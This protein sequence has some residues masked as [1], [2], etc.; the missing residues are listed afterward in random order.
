MRWGQNNTSRLSG[1]PALSPRS[2]R[3]FVP[4]RAYRTFFGRDSESENVVPHHPLP[5]E[6]A[7]S[8]FVVAGLHVIVTKLQRES[9]FAVQ[10]LFIDK[11]T[12]NVGPNSTLVI[13][14]FVAHTRFSALAACRSRRSAA[15]AG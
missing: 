10:V 4:V 8:P 3:G 1:S 13:D 9:L 2:S 5:N 7:S 12:L 15:R 11:T 6:R 14:R